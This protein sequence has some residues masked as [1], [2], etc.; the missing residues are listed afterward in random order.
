M[1]ILF[2]GTPKASAKILKYLATHNDINVIGVITQPDKPQ[3]RG[4]KVFCSEVSAEA[5]SFNIPTYKPND[6]DN[7]DIKNLIG[8]L[9]F[10]FLVVAAYGKILPDWLLN[11][12]EHMPINIHYSL[13]PQ[14][15]GAS[16]IQ[17]SLLNGDKVSG[18]TFMEMSSGLDEGKII[19]KYEININQDSNKSLL[20]EE[21]SELAISKIYEVISNVY[22]N[23]Y[24]SNQQE[25]SL[26]TYCTKIKKAD[27]I[28]N[29]SSPA[30]AIL[31][32]FRAY[33]SWPG[34]R[35]VH[36]KTMV[37]IS[38]MHITE[39]KFDGSVGS[40]VRFD[41]SGLYIKTGTKTIVITY[42]QM[43]NKNVISSADAFNAYKQFFC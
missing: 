8:S 39:E 12:P 6:L 29:F 5:K 20:E 26:A 11:L 38:K 42:L 4:K 32:K 23:K 22:T 17:S 30:E 41:K 34:V 25:E 2:A 7:N 37:K 40:I 13:L 18:V 31:N 33:Y 15:R 24:S 35:F 28:L 19:D 27:S 10:D 43:P 21:L 36:K 9:N 16:P 1:D 3:K 14:Y